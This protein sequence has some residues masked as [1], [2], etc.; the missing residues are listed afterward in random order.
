LTNEVWFLLLRSS[1]KAVWIIIVQ[2]QWTMLLNKILQFSTFEHYE[3]YLRI[4]S[5]G[6]KTFFGLSITGVYLGNIYL[7]RN[8][9]CVVQGLS[10][11]LNSFATQKPPIYH[12]YLTLLTSQIYTISWQYG[13]KNHYKW[14]L[15]RNK[16]LSFRTKHTQYDYSG[17]LL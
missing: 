15:S 17:M 16:N 6:Q 10:A 4:L 14:L 9:S 12:H 8:T 7:G 2:Y 11:H 1:V 3:Q 5:P 13:K